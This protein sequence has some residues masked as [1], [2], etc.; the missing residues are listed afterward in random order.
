MR[1]RFTLSTRILVFAIA[2]AFVI[3]AIFV[4]KQ[5]RQIFAAGG[6]VVVVSVNAASFAGPL[7]PGAIAA[8]FGTDLAM[9]LES[10]QVLPLPTTL[11]GT[12]V[13]VIDSRNV[14]YAAQLFFVSPGQVNY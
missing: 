8:A 13:R 11:A 7:S 9:R 4:A 5:S 10:A 2:I 6:N 12:S 3:G 14:G 1:A